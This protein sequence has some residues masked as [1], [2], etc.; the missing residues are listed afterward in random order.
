[1]AQHPH[2]QFTSAILAKYYQEHPYL[3]AREYHEDI[4]TEPHRME[5]P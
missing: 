1:M 3:R 2:A 4:I 5:I